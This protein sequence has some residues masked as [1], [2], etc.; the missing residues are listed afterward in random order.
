MDRSAL[1]RALCLV[2]LL[3]FLVICGLHVVGVH[4]VGDLDG[5]AL[6]DDLTA[7]ALAGGL[8]FALALFG[9]RSNLGGAGPVGRYPIASSSYGYSKPRFRSMVPL[10]R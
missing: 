4:H 9:R 7:I 8:G 1:V 3:L 5:L 6:V 10:R 2:I